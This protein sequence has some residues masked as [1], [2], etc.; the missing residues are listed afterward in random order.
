MIEDWYEVWSYE[1]HDIPYLL[2]LTPCKDEAGKFK[3]ID[4]KLNDKVVDKFPDYESA[5]L[6]LLEDEFTLVDG[7]MN[8]D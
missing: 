8:S 4:P 6:W 7:R 1:T 3:V 2:L 5:K